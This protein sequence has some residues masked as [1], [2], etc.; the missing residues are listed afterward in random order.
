MKP[1][2]CRKRKKSDPGKARII[3]LMPTPEQKQ[4]LLKW[5]GTC[6]WTYNQ[7]LAAE[8][9]GKANINQK[10]LR[11]MFLNADNFRGTELAW[12]LDTPYDIRDAALD[13]LMNAF[14]SN[15]AQGKTK[16]DMKFKSKM[17]GWDNRSPSEV[18][19]GKDHDCFI[20]LLLI[21]YYGGT[22]PPLNHFPR[23]YFT[24][25]S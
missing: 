17:K 13:D 23:N 24:I 11:Q 6:R 8:K 1:K 3:R 4:I 15:F 9:E 2:K 16:F 19:I 25:Q 12:V 21:T 5:I 18:N 22:L 7:C 20:H 10:E 14:A